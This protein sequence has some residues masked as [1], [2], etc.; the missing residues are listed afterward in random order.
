MLCVKSS[1]PHSTVKLVIHV[2]NRSQNSNPEKPK[3]AHRPSRPTGV[4]KFVL[5]KK[6]YWHRKGSL[7]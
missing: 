3:V 6:F 7:P 1:P 4:G 5:Q 2:D